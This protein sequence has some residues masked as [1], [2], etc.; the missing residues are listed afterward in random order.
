MPFLS[1]IEQRAMRQGRDEGHQEGRQEGERAI[2]L[3]QL[4]RRF[5]T[6]S[7]ATATRIASADPATLLEWADRVLTAQKL[8]DVLS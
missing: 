1:Q 4:R 2:L 7:D 5:G 8:E 6:L 3:R